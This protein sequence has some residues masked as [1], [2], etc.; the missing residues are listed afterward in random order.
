MIDIKQSLA[1]TTWN[2]KYHIVFAPKYR[3]KVFYKEKRKEVGKILRTLCEWKKVKILEAE[4]CPDHVHMLLE[5]PPKVS[6]SSFMGYLKGKSSLM[7]YEKYPELKYKYR[8]REFWCRGY[9]VMS[10]EQTPVF[11]AAPKYPAMLSKLAKGRTE[12]YGDSAR[13]P[14]W[15]SHEQRFPAA[16]Q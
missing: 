9:Y 3:R 14:T 1:H 4:V 11:F 15:Q 7:I 10:T 2:C 12:S 16:L 6:V 13:G 5:I 8:N